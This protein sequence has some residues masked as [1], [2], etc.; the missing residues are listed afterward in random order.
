MIKKDNTRVLITETPNQKEIREYYSLLVDE[1]SNKPTRFYFNL[2]KDYYLKNK[3]AIDTYI[4]MKKHGVCKK[5]TFKSG[6]ENNIKKTE[7][8]KKPTIILE[9]RHNDFEKVLI[10]MKENSIEISKLIAFFLLD[11]TSDDSMIATAT[12]LTEFEKSE[13]P[14]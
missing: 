14:F 8:D 9:M 4:E 12:I 5:E 1:K 2:C 7:Q 11:L 3:I 13:L 10:W 6:I